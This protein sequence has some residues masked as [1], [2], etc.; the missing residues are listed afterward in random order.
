[1]SVA[2]EFF[3]CQCYSDEHTLKFTYEPKDDELYTSVYLSQYRNF[4]Q[5]VWTAVRYVFGHRSRY[6]HWDCFILQRE[7][8]ER[9]RGLLDQLIAKKTCRDAVD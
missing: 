1:V 3:E 9:L 5:R 7:D 4:F 8:A 6:G 2:T